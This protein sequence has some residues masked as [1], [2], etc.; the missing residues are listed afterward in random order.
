MAGIRLPECVMCMCGP[1]HWIWFTEFSWGLC[2]HTTPWFRTFYQLLLA[3]HGLSLT[4]TLLHLWKL[5]GV[6]CVCL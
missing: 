1:P 6:Q 2:C 5:P 3:P 4:N